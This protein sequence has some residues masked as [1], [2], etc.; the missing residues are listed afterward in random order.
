MTLF[1]LQT[2]NLF[3]TLSMYKGIIG[4]RFLAAQRSSSEDTSLFVQ[5]VQTFVICD[6]LLLI[7]CFKKQKTNL[8]LFKLVR[9]N[10]YIKK[11][12]MK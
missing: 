2:S 4:V 1:S 3:F 12:K 7:E 8:N 6:A 5:A 9:C 11:L 10:F